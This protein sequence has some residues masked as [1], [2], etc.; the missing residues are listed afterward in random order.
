ML[1][2]V[3][4][5]LL[6]P[7]DRRWEARRSL[8]AYLY[9]QTGQIV[10]VGKA[11]AATIRERMSGPHK[12]KVFLS[13]AKRFGPSHGW[14]TSV[15]HGRVSTGEQGRRITKPVLRDV[16]SLLIKHLG[17]FGNTNCKGRRIERPGMTVQCIGGW[18]VPQRIF[19][20]V[21]AETVEA[22]PQIADCQSE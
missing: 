14:A 3:E 1:V 2:T 18:R 17:P 9:P 8:Y 12:E 21:S 10:Y 15:L 20:D 16:E 5:T 4:W 11:Y 6:A 13:L 22:K 19:C 7:N